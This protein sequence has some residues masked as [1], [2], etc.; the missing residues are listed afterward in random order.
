[1][2]KNLVLCGGGVKG[3][4][5]IGILYALEISKHLDKFEELAGV[6]VGG[7]II[8]LYVLGYS[9][10]DIYDFIKYFNLE[11]LKNISISNIHL[12]GL[13]IGSKFEYIVKRLIKN[14]GYS[15]NVTM[16]ELYDKTKKKITLVSVCLNTLELCHISHETFADLEVYIAI[17]MTTSIPFIYCPVSYKGN[18]YI[19]GGCMDG[20]PISIFKDKIE[21]TI[22]FLLIDS[23]EKID[24]I[25]NLETYILRVLECMMA[26]AASKLHSGYENNTVEVHVEGI[27]FIN[28]DIRDEIKDLLFMQGFKSIIENEE[29]LNKCS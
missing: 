3:I 18:L 17:R 21:E 26:G 13:D 4:A 25:D 2:K 8:V 29:N 19:D 1:M 11:K 7:L 15:E 6:S 14:K 22:G 9:P 5:H 16:K 12:F 27:N 28:Y 20:Y 23:Q 10:A 24:K